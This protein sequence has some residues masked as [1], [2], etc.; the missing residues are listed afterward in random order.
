MSSIQEVNKRLEE[1]ERKKNLNILLQEESQDED[2][3][4]IEETN[5]KLS[6]IS[7]A[8]KEIKLEPQQENN[9]LFSLESLRSEQ[10]EENNNLVPLKDLTSNS[11]VMEG[12]VLDGD[13]PIDAEKII[14]DNGYYSAENF[15]ENL[16]KRTYVGAARDLIQNTAGFVNFLGDKFFDEQPLEF[17]KL[18]PVQEP[19]YFG[20]GLSRD[21]LGFAVPFLG[22]SKAASAINTVTKI[23]KATTFLGQSFRA[24]LKGEVAVQFAFSPYEQRLSDLVQAFPTLANP[25]TEYLQADNEDSE[26]KARLKMAIEGGIVGVAFDKLLSFVVRGKQAGVKTNI[27]KD[28]SVPAKEL[29]KDRKIKNE[30]IKK[31]TGVTAQSFEDKVNLNIKKDP[32]D[33]IS[34]N[35]ISQP[36]QKKIVKFFD[37]LL[38]N[39]NL[40]RNTNIRI[41]QQMYDVLTS[42]SVMMQKGS[43]SIQSILKKNG[44]T[45][46][47]L[48][49]YFVSGARTS[50]QNLQQLSVLA[51]NYGK[52]LGDGK[53]TEDLAKSMKNS[54]LDSDILLNTALRRLDGVRRATMVGRWSTAMRNFISQQ[55]RVGMNVLYEGMQYGADKLWQKLSGKTLQRQVNPLT[56][57]EGFLN[58]WRS[59]NILNFKKNS[60]RARLKK[61]TENI[62][63]FYP[64]E[65]DRLFLRYSS[66]VANKPNLE[67]YSPISFMEKG[68]NLLNF[69]NRFQEFITRRSVFF[70]SLDGIVRGRPDIY[71]GLK[72]KDLVADE[73]LLKTIRQ[74][75]IGTAIDQ[76]LE[77]TYAQQPKK[78]SLGEKFVGFINA[79][80]FTFSLLVPFPRFLV[81][82]LKFLY[83]YS[84][85]PT[86]V[87]G[88]RVAADLPL[89][90][91]TLSTEGTYTKALMRQ[92]KEGDTTGMVKALAGWGLMGTAFQ[93]RNSKIA[94]EKWNELKVGDKTID[95]LPYNPLAAYLYVADLV[96]RKQNGTLTKQTFNIK[97][98]AKVFAGTRGGTGLYLIDQIVNIAAGEG[99]NKS[100]RAVNELVGKI[101]A[102]YLTPFKTYMG[103]LDAS[104]GNIQAAKDTKTSTLE[105]AKIDPRVSIVNNF[106]AIFNP[107]ELQDL[108]SITHAVLDE[109]TGKYVARPLKNPNPILAE[110]TGVTVR[111]D[112][113]AA[114]KE[115]DRLNF[116]Y[117]EIFKSTGIPVLDRAYKNVFAPLVH[118]KLSE[119]VQTD[120]YKSLPLSLQYYTIKESIK[121]FK[122]QTTKELQSDASLVPYLMEYQLNNIPKSQRAVIDDIIGKDYLNNLILEF[123]KK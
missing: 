77:M 22:V 50:A 111:Q 96:N 19:T 120:A 121:Q 85:A 108:T 6:P 81:N 123:Q 122:K 45:Q 25:I 39:N 47:D 56:A 60:V 21:L 71:K 119:L 92:L 116:T 40:A 104:D 118:N 1:E 23:P 88:V 26:G 112:K 72:L 74:E 98:F 29:N 51:R 107:G 43:K 37:E 58:T 113:N 99:T 33:D 14:E 68:A 115:L 102:Q 49:D 30:K 97:E 13:R 12:S 106:K 57:M 24:S 53:I 62:L 63:K 3:I 82:S 27:I 38:K 59:A 16:I 17:V 4:P 90:A 80:P 31:D 75:D 110:L 44:L 95:I 2:F 67:N 10:K 55:A 76:S 66:D 34:E 46:T 103:F 73:K 91:L 109:K 52:F 100:Y 42:Q 87:G 117:S 83:D 5:I 8:A 89:A 15:Y 114:E 48:A 65:N 94:G 36:V 54:G 64:K 79:V 105:N 93:I 11:N 69:L 61:D 32:F 9:N 41:S 7:D 78:G 35:I 84:P 70:S 28:D 86:F 101:A 18:D 20:G